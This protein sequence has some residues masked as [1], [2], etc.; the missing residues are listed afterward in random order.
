MGKSSCSVVTE[1][2][3]MWDGLKIVHGKPRRSQ[4]QGP[5]RDIKNMLVT[6]LQKNSTTHW[7]DGLRFIQVMK[8]RV[9]NNKK[10]LIF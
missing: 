1:L 4:S 3:A 6:W 5:N 8:N 10:P 7:G 9:S 2:S